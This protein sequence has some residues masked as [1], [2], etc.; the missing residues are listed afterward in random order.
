MAPRFLLCALVAGNLADCALR[1]A[2]DLPPTQVVTGDFSSASTSVSAIERQSLAGGPWYC[3]WGLQDD[4][5]WFG[6]IPGLQIRRL[7]DLAAQL[8]VEYF[9]QAEEV[10][11]S[12][13]IPGFT[14]RIT[15]I[16][17]VG[18][19]RSTWNRA[20]RSARILMVPSDSVTPGFII[21]RCRSPVSSRIPASRVHLQA[22]YPEPAL[23]I[24]LRSGLE[25]Q[26]A[27]RLVGGALK[28]M[29][30]RGEPASSTM[31]TRWARA[32]ATRS[33]APSRSPSEGARK[34][35]VNS[36]F[37]RP[38][39]IC[40]ADR[41]PTRGWAWNGSADG[42]NAGVGQRWG[43]MRSKRPGGIRVTRSWCRQLVLV[44]AAK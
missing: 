10:A 42:L 35:S 8:S 20:F 33:G 29:L 1:A 32:S 25:L 21:M 5:F 34:W 9:I 43:T 19:S 15:L 18:T 36:I 17:R 11:P 40:T 3:A 41:F 12:P 6:A 7:Q 23:V 38:G 31:A 4:V 24:A 22:V 39:G 13:S 30:T 27:G 26:L 28:P 2:A 37:S 44:R 16:R 14:M